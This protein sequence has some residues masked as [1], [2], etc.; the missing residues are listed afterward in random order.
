MVVIDPSAPHV[1][2]IG[3]GFSGLSAAFE[4]INRGRRVTIVEAD[5]QLGG[6][7]GS[8]DVGEQR[9]EKFYHH[10]FTSDDHV[11]AL[12]SELRLQGNVV[13]RP[14]STGMYYAN[15][16]FR[17]S[18]PIDVLRFTP[19][20]FFNRIRLGLLVLQARRVK[21]WR[22]LEALTAK[23]WLISLC[24]REVYRAV[25]EPLLTGKF[26]PFADDVSAVWFWNKLL[27][28]GGS[29]GAGGKEMLAYFR[30][31]FI[32]LAE[33]V[34][35][36]ISSAGGVIKTDVKATGLDVRDGHV[37]AVETSDG[38]IEA[39]AVI[40]TPALP[41]IADLLAPHVDPHFVDRLRRIRYLAN[42]CLVLELDRSLSDI[43]W[44]NVNDP[45]F[46]FVGVIEHTNF[47]PPEFYGG[48]HIVYLSKYLPE[49]DALYRMGRE[50]MLDFALPHLQRMF[51]SFRKEWIRAYHTWHARYAQPIVER[52][53][54][55]MLPPVETPV[56]NFF[57]CTMAQV[58][59][60]DRGTNYAIREG[61]SIGR[62]VASRF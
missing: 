38:R 55:R 39:N 33:A 14:S 28:R 40:G 6:L 27:L 31:G 60:E 32:A 1:V 59:P 11:M 25:W 56:S 34:A 46:P 49:T 48:R 30:G 26:G 8:F 7:A 43:Y 45:T 23:E 21:D 42:V 52:H 5:R 29:R 15:R 4:L 17:L 62:L 51:P 47:E 57:I 37:V 18:S 36:Q 54:S 9:L 16:I 24:G 12:V 61:R 3:G 50:E 22:S 2:V 35:R 53:Y 58:Y 41:I 19:L 10:W 44:L 20:S 13:L